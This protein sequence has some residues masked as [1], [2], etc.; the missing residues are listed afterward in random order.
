MGRKEIVIVNPISKKIVDI[1]NE[2]QVH[3]GRVHQP[4]CAYEMSQ[5]IH[6]T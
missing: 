5:V 6:P 3:A 2:Q 4:H 1:I